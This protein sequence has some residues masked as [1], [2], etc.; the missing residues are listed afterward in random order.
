MLDELNELSEFNAFIIDHRGSILWVSPRV[1]P[2]LSQGNPL[3]F[4]WLEFV[5]RDDFMCVQCWLKSASNEIVFRIMH[6]NSDAMLG[7]TAWVTISAAKEPW[8]D[9]LFLV[10]IKEVDWQQDG[11]QM[12]A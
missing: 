2:V 4:R 1:S 7:I 9:G 10:V 12:K 3:G 11:N 5:H 8:K 6:P